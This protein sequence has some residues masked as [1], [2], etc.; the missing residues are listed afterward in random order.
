MSKL[1]R[2]SSRWPS[3]NFIREAEFH[4]VVAIFIFINGIEKTTVMKSSVNLYAC[5]K[6]NKHELSFG[7]LNWTSLLRI[8]R[9]PCYVFCICL[10]T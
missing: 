6:T 2:S 4:Q 5:N 1:K 9:L 10:S 8:S 7:R 3:G